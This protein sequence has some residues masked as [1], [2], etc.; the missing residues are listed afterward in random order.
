MPNNDREKIIEIVEQYYLGNFN[1]IIDNVME[2]V[3]WTSHKMLNVQLKNKLDVVNFLE[4]VPV[5][6]FSFENNKFIVDDNNV[7]VEGICRYNNKEGKAIENFYCDIFTFNEN[8]IEK[9]SAYFV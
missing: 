9:V 5:G 8:K 4:H 2:D 1:A 6:R 7:V 3:T